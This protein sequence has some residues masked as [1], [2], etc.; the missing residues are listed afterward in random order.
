M[1][2]KLCSCPEVYRS[3]Q[4]SPGADKG[5]AQ[6]QERGQDRDEIDSCK[7][8]HDSRKKLRVQGVHAVR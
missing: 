6:D 2:I 5:G 1:G 7:R 8:M 3:F 4:N